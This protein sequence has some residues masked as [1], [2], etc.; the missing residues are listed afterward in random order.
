MGGCEWGRGE[1]AV[2]EV[3]VEGTA[4]TGIAFL[5]YSFSLFNYFGRFCFGN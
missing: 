3:A 1:K 5:I 2:T 4:V